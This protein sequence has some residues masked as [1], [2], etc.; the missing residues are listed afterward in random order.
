MRGIIYCDKLETGLGQF[1]KIIED[2]ANI[3]ITCNKPININT[4]KNPL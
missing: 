4:L 3:G 1:K 2:Y